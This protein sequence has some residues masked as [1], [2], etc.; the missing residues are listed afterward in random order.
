[1]LYR[2][3]K[4]LTLHRRI[5]EQNTGTAEEFAE[6]LNISRSQLFEILSQLKDFGAEIRFNRIRRT[7]FYANEF[8]IRL[9]IDSNGKRVLTNDHM[10]NS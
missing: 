10:S 2:F 9:T 5:R 7:F 4:I 8:D 3:I 1:M 6:T